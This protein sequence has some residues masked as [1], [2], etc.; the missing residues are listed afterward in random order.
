VIAF[1]SQ[2]VVLYLLLSQ[3]QFFGAEYGLAN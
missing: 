2:A 3:I 1:V